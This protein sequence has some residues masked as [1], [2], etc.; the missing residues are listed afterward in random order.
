[1]QALDELQKDAIAELLNMGM[2]HAAATLSE[3]IN[4]E[5]GL[6]IPSVE[7]VDR[8]TV[9][10]HIGRPP[11]YRISGVRETFRGEFWGDAFLLF[12]ELKS[13]DLVRAIL[14][15]SVPLEELTDMEEEVLVEVGNILLNACLSTLSDVIHEELRTEI[16]TYVAGDVSN[17]FGEGTSRDVNAKDML[18]VRIEFSVK[19]NDI[20][21]HLVL[22]LESA[23]LAVMVQRI[24]TV[25]INA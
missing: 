14:Q 12:P 4:E 13:L 7:L 10:S 24:E 5:V 15:D 1:M 3:M 18:M 21:G 20:R 25:L 22:M 2:G 17:I 11:H 23:A 6:S 16:P 19:N 8:S 9:T